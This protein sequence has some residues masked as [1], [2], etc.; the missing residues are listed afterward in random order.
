[1]R[2]PR[3]HSCVVCN[4]APCET[5]KVFLGFKLKNAK[6]VLMVG[7]VEGKSG[8]EEAGLQ[9]GDVIESCNG[10][11]TV[12]PHDFRTAL[13]SC[14]VGSLMDMKLLRKKGGSGSSEEQLIAVKLPLRTK[15]MSTED[16]QHMRKIAGGLV[17][18][19]DAAFVDAMHAA[20]EQENAELAKQAAAAAAAGA[21][22]G[23][24]SN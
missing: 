23:A 5:G 24:G 7:T 16:I 2:A 22:A 14:A 21:G 8:A 3:V 12:L 10:M 19:G 6:G 4:R 20:T 15:L 11:R 17:Q 13:Q 9:S 18:E 1:M